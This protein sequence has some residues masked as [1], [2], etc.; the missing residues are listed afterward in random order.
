MMDTKLPTTKK[1]APTYCKK[2]IDSE[3]RKINI[4]IIEN[5]VLA[6]VTSAGP[7]ESSYSCRCSLFIT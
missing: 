4:P 2:K 1:M 5:T 6:L 3:L 7:R